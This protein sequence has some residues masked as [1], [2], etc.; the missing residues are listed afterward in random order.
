MASLLQQINA[1][2]QPHDAAEF[3]ALPQVCKDYVI[4]MLSIL[5]D[6]ST[7]SRPR[8]KLA[9]AAALNSHKGRGWSL[10]AIERKFYLLRST[11]DWRCLIDRAKTSG[12]RKRKFM[13]PAVIA[14]WRGYCDVHKRSLKSAWL[15]IVTDYRMGKTIG[16]VDWRKVWEV[17][18]HLIGQPMP[19][20]C[21][22]RMPLPEGWSY[23]NMMRDK[24]R[25]IEMVASRIGR[26]EAKGLGEQVHTTRA[27]LPVGS[28]YEF[29]D[30]WHNAIVTYPG[31]IKPIRA[32]E[33]ACID[34]SSAHKVAYGLKP[35]VV[36][37]DGTRQNLNEA[38][39]RYLVAHVL[40]NIGFHRGG[41]TLFVEGGTATIRKRLA[42][43]LSELSGGLIK[44][45]V[46]GVDRK[47]PIDKWGYETKGNPDHKAHIESWHNLAQNRLDALPGYTGSNS[48]LTKPEDFDALERTVGKLLAAQVTLPEHLT[49]KLRFPVLDWATFSAVVDEVYAQISESNDHKLEGWQDRQERQWKAHAA[50]FWHSEQAFLALPAEAQTA[51]GPLIR[52][53][54]FNRVAPLSRA[55][56]WRQGQGELV[57]LPD[58]AMCMICGD[59]LAEA[60]PCPSSE[61]IFVNKEIDNKPLIYRLSSCVGIDGLRVNLEESKTFLWTINPFDPRYVFIRD[62]FG[63][64][65]GRC[66]RT[67]VVDRADTAAIG[68]EIGRT[69]REFDNLLAPLARRGAVQARANIETMK[70]NIAVLKDAQA[71]QIEQIK[72][73]R[74]MTA[75]RREA[76]RGVSLDDLMPQQSDEE[77]GDIPNLE[78]LT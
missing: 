62:T 59:D 2:I 30:M 37:P 60:R 39:M 76:I 10:K 52:Q 32:L 28:Q 3:A 44:V 65:I 18:P 7:S 33:L 47:V 31:Q 51:I 9:E 61:I 72:E 57:R 78:Q 71:M 34:I 55:Q 41:C 66:S 26:H 20:T 64:Y 35:R 23:Y 1:S 15:H 14:A 27:N 46:S 16:D 48:R 50:D 8:V 43:I 42:T 75:D 21:P 77:A 73:V 36:N 54:G 68:E 17:H 45:S 19:A 70:N 63:R 13:S 49:N 56:W 6:A 53:E 5:R 22:P 24:P 74:S 29:D 25:Q 11:R 67:D 58:Y 4:D 12:G 69:R 40:C 38:D